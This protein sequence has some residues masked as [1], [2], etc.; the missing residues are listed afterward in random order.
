MGDRVQSLYEKL[1]MSVAIATS[2]NGSK[3]DIDS[4]IWTKTRKY[5]I[6]ING[7]EVDE[8]IIEKNLWSDN[9]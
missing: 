7:L 4:F 9:L 2:D 1:W 8:L 3:Q 5:L 6:E